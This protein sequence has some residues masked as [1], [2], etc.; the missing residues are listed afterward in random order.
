MTVTVDVQ[1]YPFALVS[2]HISK[3]ASDL[4]SAGQLNEA[5]IRC[6]N[7]IEACDKW[8]VGT[9]YK[10]A[11]AWMRKPVPL[12]DIT[13]RMHAFE[14]LSKKRVD[15]MIAASARSLKVSARAEF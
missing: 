9:F 15:A 4:L 13:A 1:G 6:G 11:L 5:A 2:I 7:M 3:W 8:Y 12:Q 14:R 10:F